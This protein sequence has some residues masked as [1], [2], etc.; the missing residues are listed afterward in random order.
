MRSTTPPT[1]SPTAPREVIALVALTLE[2]NGSNY[3]LRAAGGPIRGSSKVHEWRFTAQTLTAGLLNEVGATLDDLG[4]SAL[5]L[6]VGLQLDLALEL[7][8]AAG[9]ARELL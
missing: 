3:R 9:E 4:V 6:A 8:A 5:L 7:K 2:S 1:T